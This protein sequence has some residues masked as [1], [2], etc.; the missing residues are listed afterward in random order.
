MG[1]TYQLR[2]IFN[3]RHLF[4]QILGKC[5]KTDAVDLFEAVRVVPNCSDP[6][7]WYRGKNTSQRK[8][9]IAATDH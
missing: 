2:V 4:W 8:S 3:S 1:P 9:I 6:Q 5:K 7:R